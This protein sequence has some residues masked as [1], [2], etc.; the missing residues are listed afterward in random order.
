MKKFAAGL[1]LAFFINASLF[2]QNPLNIKLNH[3]YLGSLGEILED[4]ENYNDVKFIVDQESINKIKVNS[5]PGNISLARFLDPICKLNKCEYYIDMDGVIHLGIKGKI[6]INVKPEYSVKTYMGSPEKHNYTISGK[7]VDEFS[8]ESLPFVNIIVLGSTVGTY[9]NVDGYFTLLNVPSDTSRVEISYLGYKKK[10]IY[11]NPEMDFTG[12]AYELIPDTREVG[13]VVVV[14]E[15]KDILQTNDQVGLIKFSP[16]KLSTLPNLGER[17]VFRSFQLMPGIS[18]A[19]E[20]SSGLYVRGGTPDQALVL[21]DGFTV[22][23]VE[24]LFGFYSAFNSNAIKDVQLFKGAI[25]PKYGGRLSSVANIT[26]KDGNEKQFNAAFDVGLLSV[27]GFV[28]SPIGNNTTLIL[29]GRRS[30]KSSLYNKI[31]DQYVEEGENPMLDRFR[32]QGENTARSYFYDL[33]GKLTTRPTDKDIISLS[34]Y[35]G[36]DILDNAVEPNLG[37]GMRGGGMNFTDMTMTNTDLTNWGNLGSSLK[38]S[39]QWSDKLYSNVLLSYSTYFSTRIK[40]SEGSYT[41]DEDELISINRGHIEDNQLEDYSAKADFEYRNNDWNTI[42]FGTLFTYND[43]KYNYSQNDTLTIIDRHTTGMTNSAYLQ[44]RLELMEDRLN[45]I[46]GI[47]YTYFTG[48][49]KSYFEPRLNAS[50][51]INDNIKLKASAGKY[52]QFAMRVVREDILEGSRDF[53]A[54]ADDELLPVSSSQQ[55]IAGISW[56]NPDYLVDVEAY[57]KPLHNMTE[58]SLRY[59]NSESGPP[60]PGSGT[61]VTYDENFFTGDGTARGIDV[62]LQKKLGNY[63]GWLGYTWGQVVYNF[64]DFGDYDFYANHDVTHEFKA[65]NSYK[66]RNWTFA[67]TWMYITGRPYTTPEGGYQIDLL[68]GTTSDY[69]NVSVK[70]GYR[71]PNYHRMDLSASYKFT[72]VGTMPCNINFSIFNVY[73]RKNIWYR[74]YQIIENEVIETDVNFLGFTPNISLNIKF[75]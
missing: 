6:K 63:T 75:R 21:Y 34:I 42:E 2:S 3:W 50:F 35:S 10:K 65:V 58:Y 14:A 30:W 7:V 55:Y 15:N 39:R 41:N 22:Y 57:F 74:E 48:T 12:V 29:A 36:E 25:E 72:L 9:S 20:N 73:G 43:I 17:D 19:N 26:G 56:E 45:V 32:S 5:H 38:W 53:W 11:L 59:T 8:G 31:F 68:D 71:L 18:A 1:F 4:I 66:W 54:L 62:L 44:D 69:I 40:T 23:N 61:E 51:K 33:N 67:G 46:G 49:G 27:N 16:F 28:E 37:G 70:N 52:Y 24:H 60:S 47:R 13:E 64:P